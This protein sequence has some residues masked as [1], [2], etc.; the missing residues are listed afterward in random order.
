MKSDPGIFIILILEP[1]LRP[2]RFWDGKIC[3]YL[4]T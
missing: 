4:V 1:Y 3:D 2:H